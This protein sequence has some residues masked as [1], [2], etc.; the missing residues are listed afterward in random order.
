METQQQTI[1]EEEQARV[2]K[3]RINLLIQRSGK[4]FTEGEIKQIQTFLDCRG[5]FIEV[6]QIL[7]IDISRY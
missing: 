2:D 4:Y 3:I 7:N 1:K 6:A 5:N